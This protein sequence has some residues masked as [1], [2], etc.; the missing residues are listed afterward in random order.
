[1]T[2][3]EDYDEP[4]MTSAEAEL[5]EAFGQVI[6]TVLDTHPESPARQHA[7][8]LLLACHAAVSRVLSTPTINGISATWMNTRLH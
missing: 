1:M 6:G 5:R 3:P 2:T 8:D 4:Q 7:V